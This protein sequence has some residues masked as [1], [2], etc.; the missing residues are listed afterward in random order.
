MLH[1]PCFEGSAC[2][3]NVRCLT[4]ITFDFVNRVDNSYQFTTLPFGLTKICLRILV[5]LKYTCIPYP[6][7]IILI[8]RDHYWILLLDLVC[9][10]PPPPP[11]AG[12]GGGGGDPAWDPD[13]VSGEP[14]LYPSCK[15][16]EVLSPYHHLTGKAPCHYCSFPQRGFWWEWEVACSTAPFPRR[17]TWRR[18]NSLCLPLLPNTPK[19]REIIYCITPMCV[20][21]GV[22][23][24]VPCGRSG[25]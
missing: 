24:E 25:R 10:G 8:I 12:G 2:L 20:R 18:R 9:W 11:P 22:R 15:G 1:R 23:V 19:G 4:V 21:E 7:T 6:F 5:G 3:T 13:C 16:D 17:A 14:H